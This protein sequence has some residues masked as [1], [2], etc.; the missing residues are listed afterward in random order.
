MATPTTKR[1]AIY[2]RK[3]TSEGLDS[4]FSTLE[5]QREAAEA[6]VASQR[7]EG[8]VAL[9]TIYDDGGFTGANIERPALMRLMDDV[10]AGLIDVIV[11]YKIDRLTRSLTDFSKL[12]DV[13]DAH[14]VS[15]VSVTQHFNTKDS[16]G[17]LTLNILLSFAQ[18]EREVLA[19]RVRDK[20][21]ASRK[22]GIFMG[23]TP[24]LGYDVVDRSLVV[25]EVEAKLVR[26]IFE[27]FTA[28]ASLQ[29]VTSELNSEGLTTKSWITKNGSLHE[30]KPFTNAA[31]R[32]IVTNKTYLGKAKHKGAVYD[33]D[34]EAIVSQGL[35]GKAAA[36]FK[37]PGRQRGQNSRAETKCFLKGKLFGTS[38]YAMTPAFA[39][40]PS[41]KSKRYRYYVDQKA[42]KQGWASVAL[43]SIPA[44]YIEDLVFS[45]LRSLFRCQELAGLVHKRSKADGLEC[46]KGELRY[47]L[48]NIDA[49]WDELFVG[50]Q[51]RIIDLLIERVDL[52]PKAVSLTL[53]TQ[54]LEELYQEAMSFDDE[55]RQSSTTWKLAGDG[56]RILVTKEISIRKRGGRKAIITPSGQEGDLGAII[57]GENINEDLVRTIAQSWRWNRM[58][59]QGLNTREIAAKE[60]YG[61]SHVSRVMR[62]SSLPPAIVSDIIHGRQADDLTVKSLTMGGVDAVW[63]GLATAHPH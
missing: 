27:R 17:R 53:Y 23:G 39:K 19:E 37:R 29:A 36:I 26:R 43:P 60:G 40:S 33:A 15:F 11:C 42:S 51:L 5:A 2:T 24:P 46:E 56:T 4:A 9:D 47:S 7:H 41:N 12:V 18:F 21:A 44:G 57:A 62:L 49:L 31:V 10:K 52:A 1:C 3:S 30:G 34:H 20:V 22:K 38:G 25:N 63:P 50:E 32:A 16:M 54:G 55:Q 48:S 14:G 45:E 61:I 35:F 28:T 13:F 6:Y 58:F 59:D 8:W